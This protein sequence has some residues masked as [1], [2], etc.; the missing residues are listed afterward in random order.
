M[1]FSKL[2]TGELVAAIGGLILLVAMFALDWYEISGFG[3][4]VEQ[5]GEAVGVDTGIKAWD[6]Q[7]FFGTIA[8]LVILAAALA[9][10]TLAILTATA[11]NVALPVA[12]SAIT[13]GLGIAAVA[14]VLLRMVFQPGPN[15]VVDL[16]FGILLALIGAAIVAYGGW[17]AMQ[18]EGTTFDQARGQLRTTMATQDAPPAEPVAP[19]GPP[20]DEPPP[21]PG[22][23]AGPETSRPPPRTTP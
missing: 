4:L 5:F 6:G 13:A 15:E 3:G 9:A 22:D 8:N 11:R 18:E 21:E 23:T 19:P 10:V 2:R 12:A 20:R 7:G 16:R 1:D 14:M 17:R